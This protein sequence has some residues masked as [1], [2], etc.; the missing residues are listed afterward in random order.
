MKFIINSCGILAALT[1]PLPYA[2]ESV[3]NEGKA[4]GWEDG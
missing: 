2:T 3:R 4:I 1:L